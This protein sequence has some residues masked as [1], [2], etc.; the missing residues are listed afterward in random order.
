MCRSLAGMGSLKPDAPGMAVVRELGPP[1]LEWSASLHQRALGSGLFPSLGV[2]FLAC[3][4]E[5]FVSSPFGVALVAE[6][7]GRPVGFVIGCTDGVGHGAWVARRRGRPLAIAGARALGRRPHLWVGFVRTRARR[8]AMGLLRLRRTRPE[9][10][11][12]PARRSATLS[13]IAVEP[14]ARGAAVGTLLLRAFEAE[15]ERRGVARAELRTTDAAGFYASL[16]WR[17]TGTRTDLDGV[18]HTVL[19]RELEDTVPPRPT[20]R[21]Y[22]SGSESAGVGQEII[23]PGEIRGAGGL[24]APRS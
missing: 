15:I 4:H 6:A 22:S 20:P 2:A 10:G 14:S 23:S 18:E 16:G 9:L 7:G 11:Q 24:G 12:P 5:C 21:A 8:Y 13:H 1:E 17:P 3:Y 19:V